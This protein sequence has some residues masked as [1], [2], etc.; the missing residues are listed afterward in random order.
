MHC[1]KSVQMRRFFLSVF[2]YIRT[3]YWK[4]RARKNSVH[5]HFP[6]SDGFKDKNVLGAISLT[7]VMKILSIGINSLK[8]NISTEIFIQNGVSLDD[9]FLA[10]MLMLC[11]IIP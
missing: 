9:V 3:E 6:R 7:E 11:H 2:S 10:L 8:T 5:G 4:I 1:V